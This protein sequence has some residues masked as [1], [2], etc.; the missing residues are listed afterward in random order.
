MLRSEH[1]ILTTHTGSL[2]R[3]AALTE[4]YSRRAGGEKVDEAAID[5]AG[6]AAV[7]DVVRKQIQA[8]VDVGNNGE[9]QREAFFLY[10]R[11]RM[12]GFGGAWNRRP[13]AD[14]TRYPD[15]RAWTAAQDSLRPSVSNR[16]SVPKAIGEVQYL[17]PAFIE[18]EC[19]EFQTAL[20][21]VG[22]TGFAEPFMTA[23]S[24]GII[25][26]AMKNEYYDTEDAYLAA[27]GA[28][29][30]VEYEAIVRH[31]F[32]L[33]IDA[34]D[35]ALERHITYQ[36][37]PVTEFVDFAERVVAIINNALRNIPRD[38]VR[39]HACWGNYEGPHDS[40]VDLAEILPV[41]SRAKVGGWVLPFAN[42]RHAHE[43]RCLKDLPL[44]DG[45]VIVAGVIDPLTNFVEHPEV[46]ADRL[47]RVAQVVSDPTRVL[48]GT[49]CGFDTSAGRG[50]V[51]PDV[52]WAKLKAMS[53]GARIASQRL[54][55]H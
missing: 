13:F 24:P 4:L 35:L 9:Q 8:G 37:R 19:N 11:H 38:R 34:P 21:E 44:D 12:S 54:G 32:V 5:Q 43:Y 42:P 39:I 52:V 6:T 41:I 49:D 55:M 1:R 7:R 17:D 30:Q 10:V 29:L 3:P 22:G 16:D 14:L 20:R 18:A 40:D 48:A 31:G 33:Q 46:V 51:A 27:L 28:A 47:E 53:D 45:Q 25:A 36:D 26:A 15:Y 50:R 2:P 23:P